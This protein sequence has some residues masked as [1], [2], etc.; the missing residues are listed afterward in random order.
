VLGNITVG[1]G[2]MV[3]AGSLVLKDIPPH[4]LVTVHLKSLDGNILPPYISKNMTD[5]DLF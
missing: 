1:E 3:A 4:R 2:A 5:A